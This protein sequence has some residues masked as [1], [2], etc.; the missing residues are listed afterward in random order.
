MF[1]TKRACD[2]ERRGRQQ[3][4]RVY[5]DDEKKRKKRK[6]CGPELKKMQQSTCGPL[7]T[8]LIA[9]TYNFKL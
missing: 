3:A 1:T 5:R 9:R 6:K 4:R 2:F 7:F 8:L